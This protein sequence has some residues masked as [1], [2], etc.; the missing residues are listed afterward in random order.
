M[1]SP[2]R[3][4][5]W[6]SELPDIGRRPVLVLSRDAAIRARR[7]A[8]V[9]PCTTIIRGLESEV[10]LVPGSDPVPREC[11]VSLDALEQIP[12]ALLVQ[13]VGSISGE[14]LVEV[15]QALAVAVDCGT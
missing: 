15:C 1:T 2:R 6:W 10:R 5:I 12:T 13:R 4:D 3:G 9:A 7:L 14:Q 11:V 8:I